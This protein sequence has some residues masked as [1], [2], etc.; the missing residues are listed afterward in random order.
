M[1]NIK[2]INKK[3]TNHETLKT[4]YVDKLKELHN[5]ISPKGIVPEFGNNAKIKKLIYSLFNLTEY[6]HNL[7]EIIKK[8]N[9]EIDIIKY[10]QGH[11]SKQLKYTRII[12]NKLGAA[13]ESFEALQTYFNNPKSQSID[14]IILQYNYHDTDPFFMELKKKYPYYM[15]TKSYVSGHYKSKCVDRVNNAYALISQCFKRFLNIIYN[16]KGALHKNEIQE[17]SKLDLDNDKMN[18]E[19]KKKRWVVAKYLNKKNNGALQFLYDKDLLHLIDIGTIA[20]IAAYDLYDP[21]KE[22]Y[23]DSQ[24]SCFTNSVNG[25]LTKGCLTKEIFNILTHEA[26]YNCNGTEDGVHNIKYVI[27]ISKL[28]TNELFLLKKETESSQYANDLY[29]IQLHSNPISMVKALRKLNKAIKNDD[30][31]KDVLPIDILNHYKNPVCAFKIVKELMMQKNMVGTVDEV[32][33]VLPYLRTLET[34]EQLRQVAQGI[35]ILQRKKISVDDYISDLSSLT[36]KN[37]R[38]F[39]SIANGLIQLNKLIDEDNYRNSQEIKEYYLPKILIA[40]FPEEIISAINYLS[41]K[42]N[43]IAFQKQNHSAFTQKTIE[44]IIQ[45]KSPQKAAESIYILEK[46][47][48]LSD[49]TLKMMQDSKYPDQY[50]KFLVILKKH[51][52][53]DLEKNVSDQLKSGPLCY[54]LKYLITIMEKLAVIELC[55]DDALGTL[56]KN[57]CRINHYL[58]CISIIE[59]AYD[60]TNLENFQNFNDM[61]LTIIHAPHENISTLGYAISELME[62]S[63]SGVSPTHMKIF[64]SKNFDYKDSRDLVLILLAMEKKGI[65]LT[66]DRIELLSNCKNINTIAS[67]AYK[68]L[69]F[70]GQFSEFNE[71]YLDDQLEDR[72]A[73]EKYIMKQ[74]DAAKNKIANFDKDERTKIPNAIEKHL[75]TYKYRDKYK[76]FKEKRD[77][78]FMCIISHDIP[79]KRDKYIPV[80]I[81][82][83][84]YTYDASILELWLMRSQYCNSRSLKS[85]GSNKTLT[86]KST[87]SFG[88]SS[89][90]Y[91]EYKE[92]CNDYALTSVISIS[93]NVNGFHPKTKSCNESFMNDQIQ[94]ALV[95]KWDT[96]VVNI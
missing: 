30:L 35:L 76:E 62:K 82:E 93:N 47:N 37:L 45:H 34:E 75:N 52:M 87:I 29:F 27:P 77:E 50:A 1:Q 28:I 86:G 63:K 5:G 14:S 92:L 6:D 36:D 19:L 12:A 53:S 79:E 49:A 88:F 83:E 48:L 78:I 2:L 39:E 95:L 22:E 21:D 59:K 24:F 38:R 67:E 72:E 46:N 31:I 16:N 58:N 91:E 4:S 60:K 23:A 96:R 66:E 74:L 3:I 64:F 32:N 68:A 44:M 51:S 85:P 54:K 9:D 84:S 43:L 55:N 41:E 15:E 81:N 8:I 18:G 11:I 10:T 40:E 94:S 65:L 20:R 69:N 25:F 13:W 70:T 80:R 57:F 71:S 26:V 90:Q 73:V 42:Y 33:A 89:K 17:Q 56:V 61:L 7:S